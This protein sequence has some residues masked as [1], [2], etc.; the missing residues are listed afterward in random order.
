M[1]RLPALLEEHQPSLVIIELGGN[2]G[3]RGYPLVRIRQ[4]LQQL[5]KLTTDANAQAVLVGMQIPPNYGQRYAQGFADL[6]LALAEKHDL[7]VIPFLL[8][9]VALEPGLMQSDGIHPTAAAQPRI[10]KNVLPTLKTLLD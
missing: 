2:D 10:L 4:N 9:G 5:I 8:E 3:L 6:Y 7:A 1:Q